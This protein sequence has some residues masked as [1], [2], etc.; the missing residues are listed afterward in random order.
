MGPF[1][2]NLEEMEQPGIPPRRIP[3]LPVLPGLNFQRQCLTALL[4][5]RSGSEKSRRSKIL[6]G[7]LTLERR[8]E[9]CLQVIDLAINSNRTHLVFL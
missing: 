4:F 6:Q 7:F 3:W 5:S 9:W 8:F 1:G 2:L